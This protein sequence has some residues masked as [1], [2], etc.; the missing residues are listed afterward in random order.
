M[1]LIRINGVDMPEP[2]AY[3]FEFS[4]LD[5]EKTGRDLNFKLVRA[6]KRSRVYSVSVA[7]ENIGIDKL[8]KIVTATDPVFFQVR[9]FDM[10][11]GQF[12]EKTMYA[13]NRTVKTSLVKPDL[14]DAIGS[15]SFNLIEQ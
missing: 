14:S 13:G 6:R 2:T 1:A 7:W 15:I 10:V 11:S 12:V 5:T 4:D 3:D 9:L 8:K